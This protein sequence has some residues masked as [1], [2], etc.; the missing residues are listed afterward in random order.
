MKVIPFQIPRTGTASIHV[1]TDRVPHFYNH[2]HQ[3]PEIQLTL[4]CQS[5][6]TLI[7]GDYIGRFQEGDVFVIGSNQPHVFR[8]DATY[9]TRKKKAVSI[10][11]FFD[12]NSLGVKFWQQEELIHFL[13]FFEQ[14]RT[15]YRITGEKQTQI[16]S[17]LKQLSEASGLEK[18]ILFLQLIEKLSQPD[19]LSPLSKTQTQGSIKD[20]DGSRLN[21]IIAHTFRE[22]HREIPLSE[23]GKIAHMTVTA[24]CKYFKRRTGKTY[25]NFL[26]EI[27]ISHACKLLLEKESPIS[28]IS[29]ASGFSN[30]S[31]FNRVFKKITGH[32]P[33]EYRSAV[34]GEPDH[35]S[36]TSPSRS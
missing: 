24:F 22:Y 18:L 25:L 6:G 5:V 30:L 13:P 3:H 35:P 19:H 15:G 23:I 17:L 34:N 33:R 20:D 11:V 26:Q 10:T 2:L 28:G 14:S 9:L 21:R 27:R 31:N 1:Q 4:I 29:D 16:A 36:T 7:A 8:N 32:S 12:E